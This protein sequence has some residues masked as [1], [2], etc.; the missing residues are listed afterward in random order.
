MYQ[1]A[2]TNGLLITNKDFKILDIK[3]VENRCLV[4]ILI[5]FVD[6]RKRCGLMFT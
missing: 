6:Q 5:F 3:I 1:F 2:R 4:F